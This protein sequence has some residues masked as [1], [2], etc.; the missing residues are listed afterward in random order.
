MTRQTPRSNDISNTLALML[1]RRLT[2]LTPKITPLSRQRGKTN[3]LTKQEMSSGCR[4]PYQKLLTR[5]ER[6]QNDIWAAEVTFKRMGLWFDHKFLQVPSSIKLDHV[7]GL[8]LDE[9][10]GFTLPLDNLLSKGLRTPKCRLGFSRVVCSL[11]GRGGFA[12]PSHSWSNIDVENLDLVS[13]M[14]SLYY[15]NMIKSFPRDTS[16]GRDGLRAKDCLLMDCLSGVDVA[17]FDDVAMIGHSLDGYLYDLEF[18]VGVS[19]G[20]EAILHVVNWV[21]ILDSFSISLVDDGIIIG[22]ILV[23]GKVLELIMKDGPRCGLHLNV[24][25]TKVF[26]QRKTQR[27]AVP[28]NIARPLHRV[29]LRE[30]LPNSNFSSELVMK[31]VAKTIE[32]KDAIA[33]INDQVDMRLS[34]GRDKL[35]R[36]E[37]MLLYS[38]T[39]SLMYHN[40]DAY[41][42]NCADIGY[43]F[44]PFSFSS[45]GELKKDAVAFW[46]IRE[47]C[48]GLGL[49]EADPKV[50]RGSRHWGAR[51]C[52][53]L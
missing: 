27:L 15:G 41:E 49:T 36:L 32:L 28:P 53:H 30:G 9:R 16:C 7:E 23:V 14:P 39:E 24:D 45:F 43:G 52:S 50:L 6:T 2:P 5:P 10:D 47:G 19:G 17:I 37:D 8:G 48:S 12:E 44:L 20:C 11:R 42:A 51:C 25:K 35:V 29:K 46:G 18:G 38:C 34:G 1:N 26:W 4:S 33:M 22:D 31:R 40:V 13:G 3:I 21:M